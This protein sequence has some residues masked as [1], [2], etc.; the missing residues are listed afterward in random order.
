MCTLHFKGFVCILYFLSTPDFLLLNFS[1]LG[2]TPPGMDRSSPDNSPVHGMLRQPSITTGVNIPIITELGRGSLQLS[3][4]AFCLWDHG[5][6]KE[7]GL[8][9]SFYRHRRLLWDLGWNSEGKVWVE[10]QQVIWRKNCSIFLKRQIDSFLPAGSCFQ[11][12]MR[13]ALKLGHPFGKGKG[14]K[15]EFFRWLL[16]EGA[17]SECCFKGSYSRNPT[18]NL[19]S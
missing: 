17:S 9:F 16:L 1:P 2:F 8:I 10:I 6:Y 5:G 15:H 18:Q 7:F 4:W 11:R 12:S 14:K 3:G 19:G 13:M